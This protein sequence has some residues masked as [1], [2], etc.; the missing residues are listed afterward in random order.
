MP[1]PNAGKTKK[2]LYKRVWFWVVIVLVVFL[3]YAISSSSGNK[4][5]SSAPKTESASTSQQQSKTE[6]T[7]KASQAPAT[8]DVPQ[9]YK[10]ALAKA[11][12]YSDMMHM[13]KR[14]IYEQLTSEADQFKPEAA[15]YAV[16]NL[17][18]DYNAN[19]LAKA[20]TYQKTMNMSPAAI[21]DQLTSDAGEKFTPEEAEYAV[22]HLDQ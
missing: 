13:S 15:Q 7:A 16:D 8:P 3:I 4:S 19:A 20:K 9:E 22:Q 2:P 5:T 21:K 12:N 11:Q 1:T 14:G 17:Q 10:S 6:D 18:A